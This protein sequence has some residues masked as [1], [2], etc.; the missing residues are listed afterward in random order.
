MSWWGALTSLDEF[1]L[2]MKWVSATL[3]QAKERL[4]KVSRP[5]LFG[6]IDERR[7]R[8]K[9][10]TVQVELESLDQAV[11]TYT[12]LFLSNLLVSKMIW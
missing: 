12:K 4:D 8:E 6:G 2:G 7:V 3:K 5:G 11:S 9:E 1:G 10:A